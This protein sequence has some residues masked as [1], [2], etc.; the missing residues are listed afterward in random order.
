MDDLAATDACAW[1][2]GWKPGLLANQFQIELNKLK[3]VH[4]IWVRMHTGLHNTKMLINDA[5]IEQQEAEKGIKPSL[6]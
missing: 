6:I 4:D 3:A 2:E 1:T 5:Q